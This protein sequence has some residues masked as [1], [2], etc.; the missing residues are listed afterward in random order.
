MKIFMIAGEPSGD[1]LGQGLIRALRA[2][3]PG[4]EI[5]GVGGESM[6]SEGFASLFPMHEISLMGVLPVLANLRNVLRRIDQTARAVIAARPD[7]LVIIDSPDF[8][9]RVAR[10]VRKILPDVKIVNYVGPT[11]WAW[12][13]GRAKKM[14]AFVDLILAIFPFEPEVH[15]R[16][17][18]PR[19]VYIGHPLIERRAA[20]EGDDEA[21]RQGPVL[22]LPGSRASVIQRMGA[23]FGE[24]VT[25]LDA[26]HPGLDYVLPTSRGLAEKVEA[27]IASWSVKPRVA[28]G[29]EEKSAAFRAARAALAA[30]GTVTLE[31][32]LSRTPTIVAYKVP[33]IEEWI[34]RRLIQVNM[35][36]Q[37]NIIL[38]EMAFPEM[39]QD[40]ANGAAL[41]EKLAEIIEDGPERRRQLEAVGRLGEKLAIGDERR[42]SEKAAEA[43]HD[44]LTS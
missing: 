42:P 25:R 34:A 22:V 29:E 14:R 20:L 43:I 28:V 10:R 19:C 23:V 16:L 21:K 13:P 18:G 44:L 9:H 2:K 30:S 3:I 26:V 17:G 11:V 8:N 7:A 37:P 5:S 32:A 33:K 38:G 39:L 15:E 36:A 27:L 24:A 6:I 1:L 40:E 35:V 12:R 41:A 31:L 4:V